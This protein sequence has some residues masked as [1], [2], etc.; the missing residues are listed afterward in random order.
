MII[1]MEMYGQQQTEMEK[2]TRLVGFL[3]KPQVIQ[4]LVQI[5]LYHV[6]QMEL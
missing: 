2:P 5:L 4:L 3:S 6:M 1:L